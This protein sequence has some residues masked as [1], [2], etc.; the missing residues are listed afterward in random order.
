M[1]DDWSPENLPILLRERSLITSTAREPYK[2]GYAKVTKQDEDSILALD[3]M[4]ED[5]P[6]SV[7]LQGRYEASD[8]DWLKK[9]ID[10]PY[11]ISYYFPSSPRSSRYGKGSYGKDDL[12]Y[13]ALYEALC[14]SFNG[15]IRFIESYF[16]TTFKDHMESE[17]KMAIRMLKQQIANEAQAR[18][19]RH[20]AYLRN[21][22]VWSKPL[23]DSTFSE[24]AR[25]TKKD[26]INSLMTGKIDLLKSTVSLRTIQARAKLGISGDKMFYATGRLIKSIK[27]SVILLSKDTASLEG[28]S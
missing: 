27:V 14:N 15:G 23:I 18:R 16:S 8:T 11:Q 7:R 26:I 19:G 28:D 1:I 17:Y 4:F 13:K 6:E 20:K 2:I 21:F 12:T 3:N 25:K 9:Y 10:I 24:L 5:E 22:D